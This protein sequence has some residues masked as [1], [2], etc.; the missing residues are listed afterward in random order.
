[1]YHA[2][3]I[4]YST[5]ITTAEH[6]LDFEITKDTQYLTLTGELWGVLCSHFGEN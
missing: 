5:A 2:T 4:T 1:M 6:E 3:Y